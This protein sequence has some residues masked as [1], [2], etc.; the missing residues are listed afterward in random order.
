MV[1]L[2]FP[3]VWFGFIETS[4]VV[5]PVL[6]LT[7]AF[8]LLQYQY[9]LHMNLHHTSYSLKKKLFLHLEQLLLSPIIGFVSTVPTVLALLK[10]PKTFEIVRK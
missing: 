7:Y 10:P 8:W 9:G 6:L 1:S 4:K 2:L 3:F 5:A